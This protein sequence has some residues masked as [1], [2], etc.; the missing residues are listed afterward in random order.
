MSRRKPGSCLNN[1][2]SPEA[3]TCAHTCAPDKGEVTRSEAGALVGG[4]SHEAL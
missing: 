1:E 3:G 4:G 2:T